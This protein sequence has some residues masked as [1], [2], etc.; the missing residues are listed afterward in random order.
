MPLDDTRSIAPV[1]GV[2]LL[3]ALTVCLGG[4]V[5]IAVTSIDPGE[6]PPRA[7]IEL[8]VESDS[9]VIELEHRHG[10]SLDVRDLDVHVAVEGESLTYQPPVPFFA[11]DGF[12]G[13]PTGPFNAEADPR[14]RAGQTAG[15]RVASTNAPSIE[16]GDRV[17]VTMTTN[18]AVIARL[19]TTA[20]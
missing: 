16:A 1:V 19:E 13:G 6:P 7:A 11:A 9:G 4:V 10:D 2:V 17:V 5:A 15:V 3:L 12:R 18:G 14:W 20:A 8:T